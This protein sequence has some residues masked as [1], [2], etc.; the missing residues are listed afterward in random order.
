MRT[1]PFHAQRFSCF[2]RA[3]MIRNLLMMVKQTPP[4]ARIA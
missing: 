3:G 2:S 4:A 1:A